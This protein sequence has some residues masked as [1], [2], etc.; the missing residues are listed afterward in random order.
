[1]NDLRD[2]PDVSEIAPPDGWVLVQPGTPCHAPTVWHM[3]DGRTYA[4]MSPSVAP[5]LRTV[6][7]KLADLERRVMRIEVAVERIADAVQVL[8][9][10][11]EGA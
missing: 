1:V 9:L 3:P 6:G 8:V 5:D 7:D 4:P 10:E 11:R 2:D